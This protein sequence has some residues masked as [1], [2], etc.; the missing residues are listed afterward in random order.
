MSEFAIVLEQYQPPP[1]EKLSALFQAVLGLPKLDATT[2]AARA[3]G[4]LAEKLDGDQARRLQMALGNMQVPAQAVPQALV[5]AT[6]KG[7]RVQWISANAEHFSVRWTFTGPID[8]HPWSDVLVIS[9]AVVLHAEKEQVIKTTTDYTLAGHLTATTR[10]RY[11]TTTEITHRDVSRD[12]GMATITLGREPQQLRTLRFRA[13]EMEYA[14]MFSAGEA[15]P[16]ALENFCLLLARIGNF[17][18]G[19]HITDETIELIAAASTTPRLPNSPRFDSED[20]FDHY[21]RWLVARRLQQ[22]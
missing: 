18:T 2:K 13:T 3:T 14:T 8:F 11:P 19:A 4:I 12:M 15:R 16:T 7:R 9:A 10:G 21:Q 17:A 1:P 6:V 5:P 20:A 22:A